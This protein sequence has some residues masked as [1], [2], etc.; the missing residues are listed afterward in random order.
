MHET[1][2]GLAVSYTFIDSGGSNTQ[3]VYNY[4]KR[5]KGGRVFAIKGRGG[6]GIPIVGAPNRRRSGKQ[7]RAVDL[8][9]LGVDNAK[10][11]VMKR[12]EI[13]SP[14]QGYCHFPADREA[15]W[16]RGLTAETMVTKMFKGRPRREWKVIEGRRNEPLDCRVYA[17][18][19][20]VMASPQFDK[21]ALR[22]KRRTQNMQIEKEKPKTPEKEETGQLTAQDQAPPA[23][24]TPPKKSKPPRTRGSFI[25]RWRN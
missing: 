23:Q 11:V 4:V 2:A 19:A 25:N 3:A 5:H 15:G 22:M 16:F 8:Y 18:A 14:G 9:I 17:F 20:L 21:L 6:E 1:G 7:K 10:S 13:D 12:L 24:D